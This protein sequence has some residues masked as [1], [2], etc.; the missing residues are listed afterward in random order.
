MRKGKKRKT[1]TLSTVT[2]QGSHCSLNTLKISSATLS[3]DEITMTMMVMIKMI[4]MVMME[5]WKWWWVI[6]IIDH[7]SESS[8]VSWYVPRIPP[9]VEEARLLTAWDRYLETTNLFKHLTDQ[10]VI[11]KCH[12][13]SHR[14]HHAAQKLQS[15]ILDLTTLK[16]V[17]IKSSLETN[18]LY[19]PPVVDN[20][21]NCE[22]DWI[23]GQNLLRRHLRPKNAQKSFR[24]IIQNIVWVQGINFASYFKDKGRFRPTYLKHLD[25]D[26][27]KGGSLQERKHK[28]NTWFGN[29]NINYPC[30]RHHGKWILPKTQPTQR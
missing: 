1:S 9:R 15:S 7:L 20:C 21:V 18:A 26:V 29:R 8:W 30:Q 4:W 3:L 2:P 17:L 27:N 5:I 13:C 12:S 10:I 28:D 6:L 14:I 19:W 16:D 11:E 24:F 22:S 25:P 23:G